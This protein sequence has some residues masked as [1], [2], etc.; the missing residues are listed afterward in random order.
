MEICSAMES[1]PHRAQHDHP[2]HRTGT[3]RIQLRPDPRRSLHPVELP[4]S[5]ARHLADGRSAAVRSF[6]FKFPTTTTSSI[7][8]L[9]RTLKLRTSCRRCSR[10]QRSLSDRHGDVYHDYAKNGG[11]A[12]ISDAQRK[13]L[14]Q[15]RIRRVD[16]VGRVLRPLGWRRWTAD[17]ARKAMFTASARRNTSRRGGAREAALKIASTR[18]RPPTHGELGAKWS[19]GGGTSWCPPGTPCRQDRNKFQKFARRS[20]S[21][22]AS[23]PIMTRARPLRAR[24]Q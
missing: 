20:T 2:T 8:E 22:T 12:S 5:R 11:K 7:V 9:C 23:L 21:A 24:V 10:S 16:R 1:D 15:A 4:S 6:H 13:A 19:P 14:S 17:P 18:S 3:F